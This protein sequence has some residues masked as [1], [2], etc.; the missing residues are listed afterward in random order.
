MVTVLLLAIPAAFVVGM[1][2]AWFKW[3]LP[4]AWAAW[5]NFQLE[6]LLK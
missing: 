4:P 2:L 6:Q 5:I 3:P 1:Y